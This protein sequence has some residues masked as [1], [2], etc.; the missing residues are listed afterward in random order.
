MYLSFSFIISVTRSWSFFINV[1]LLF[2]GYSVSQLYLSVQSVLSF[3]LPIAI[4]LWFTFIF[5]PR[6][7]FL[8]R[9]LSFLHSILPFFVFPLFYFIPL[10]FLFSLSLFYHI[11]LSLFLSFFDLYLLVSLLVI[12]P[13]HNLTLPLFNAFF[14]FTFPLFIPVQCS[15]NSPC[16]RVWIPPGPFMPFHNL[17]WCANWIP[18]GNISWLSGLMCRT[19]S[20]PALTLDFS[21]TSIYLAHSSF[22]AI[23]I[24]HKMYKYP[25]RI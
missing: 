2:I 19:L 9:S 8:S 17:S 10:L 5:L 7:C 1:L 24:N 20:R 18:R 3:C 15:A 23:L 12:L 25:R 16:S 13:P 22:S 21:L 14:P 11:P 6:N 4:P